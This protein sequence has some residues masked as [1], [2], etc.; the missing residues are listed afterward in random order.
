M[1]ARAIAAA[2]ARARALQ[3][4][5]LALGTASGRRFERTVAVGDPQ[6][7]LPRVLEVLVRHGLLGDD[8]WVRPEVRLVSV[9]DHFDFGKTEARAVAVADSTAL[10]S[11]LASHPSDQVVLVLGNHDLA[12]V[13]ELHGFDAATF[14]ALQ[15][16]ADAAYRGGQTDEALE[17]AFL[18]KWPRFPDVEAVARDFSGYAPAQSALVARVIRG[19]R[20][21]LAWAAG[22]RVLVT[23]AGITTADLVHAGLPVPRTAPQAQA[24]LDG[25]LRGRVA[26][27][28]EGPLDLAPLHLPGSAAHGVGRGICFQRP[29]YPAAD[30]VDLFDGPPRR[31]FDPRDLLKGITQVVGH[32]RDPK[33]RL[34]LGPWVQGEAP[35]DGPVRSLRLEGEGARYETGVLENASMIFVDGGMAHADPAAYEL[36]DLATLTP[37]R[38]G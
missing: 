36:L 31:R 32:I 26:A 6:A 15:A 7:P 22:E 10:L 13:S 33:C 27:W 17:E 16:Q 25:F 12:R 5:T 20:A 3:P 29:A 35:G 14:T 24:T 21:H 9:G 38:S 18:A 8:G 28:G 2:E 4:S 19:G 1:R 30:E 23:H 11:W 34:L 37:L